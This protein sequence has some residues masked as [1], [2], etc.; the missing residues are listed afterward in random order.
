MLQQ[1]SSLAISDVPAFDVSE[2]GIKRENMGSDQVADVLH[3][4]SKFWAD[5]VSEDEMGE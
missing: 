1:V 3:N 5:I 2:G 4:I